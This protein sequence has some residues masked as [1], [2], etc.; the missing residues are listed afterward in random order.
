MKNMILSLVLILGFMAAA[1]ADEPVVEVD[2][3]GAKIIQMLMNDS[4]QPDFQNFAKGADVLSSATS[5]KTGDNETT[6]VLKGY[7]TQG[8][9]AVVG[10]ATLTITEKMAAG[11]FGAP[12]TV[13]RSKL[14]LKDFG[15]K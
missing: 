3:A 12:V 9:D 4:V 7:K 13:Y 2:A 14:E 8:G 15:Q 11:V 6:Y 1:Q 5:Q 10:N